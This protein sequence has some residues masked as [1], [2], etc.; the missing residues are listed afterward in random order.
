M[1]RGYEQRADIDAAH[2]RYNSRKVCHLRSGDRQRLAAAILRLFERLFPNLPVV[3][4][5]PILTLARSPLAALEVSLRRIP[6]AELE[7]ALCLHDSP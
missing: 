2:V 7:P 4:A 1:V 3:I 5:F 6:S